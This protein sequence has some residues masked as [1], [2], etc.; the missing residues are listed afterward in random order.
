MV[1]VA[2]HC[3]NKQLLA[4]DNFMKWRYVNSSTQSITVD[5]STDLTENSNEPVPMKTEEE[6]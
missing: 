4:H 2:A 1:H 5:Y 6:R 3:V